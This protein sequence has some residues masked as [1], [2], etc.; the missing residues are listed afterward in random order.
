MPDEAPQAASATMQQELGTLEVA[1][2]VFRDL[3]LKAASDVAGVASVGRSSG[4]FRRRSGAEAVQ[5][6]RAEGEVAFSLHLSARYDARIPEM[7]DEVRRRVKALV[8]ATT[9]Y[10]VRAINITVEHILPPESGH[11]RPEAPAP[12]P[13][14][15]KNS[16]GPGP[17]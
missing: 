1:D 9:G 10:K 17:Q 2:Q 7:V 3:A 12:P 16:S 13:E 15:P 5:V 4:F 14:L 11:E 8:E 6:E